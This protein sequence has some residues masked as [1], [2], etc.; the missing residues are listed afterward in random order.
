MWSN[1][2]EQIMDAT[3]RRTT[4]VG[5]ISNKVQERRLQWYGHVIGRDEDHVRTRMM[6]LQVDGGRRRGRPKWRWID[7]IKGDLRQNGLAREDRAEPS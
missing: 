3:M 7:N 1:E 6:V 4:K 5:E 2:D